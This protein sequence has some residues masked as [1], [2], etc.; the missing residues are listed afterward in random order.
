MLTPVATEDHPADE[1]KPP[2]WEALGDLALS[3]VVVSAIA[4]IVSFLGA[5][6]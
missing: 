1:L 6:S 5:T 2:L 4:L 3:V